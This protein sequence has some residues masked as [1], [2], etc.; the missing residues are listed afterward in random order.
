MQRRN[1]AAATSAVGISML[2][3]RAAVTRRHVGVAAD[4]AKP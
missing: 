1:A 3:V 4:D 2:V